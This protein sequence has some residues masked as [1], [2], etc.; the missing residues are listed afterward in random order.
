MYK[1]IRNNADVID[2]VNQRETDLKIVPGAN[3]IAPKERLYRQL[4][5]QLSKKIPLQNLDI[6]YPQNSAQRN[7]NRKIKMQAKKLGEREMK[8]KDKKKKLD[9][10]KKRLERLLKAQNK[11]KVITH[12]TKLQNMLDTTPQ[13]RKEVVK[14]AL[15]GQV[16]NEQLKENYG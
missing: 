3:L 15:F 4:R 7:G 12:Q 14:K 11:A 8:K 9:K 10:Y 6:H 16:L 1:S 2:I 13:A 5:A